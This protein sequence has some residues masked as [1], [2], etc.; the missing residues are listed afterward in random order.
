MDVLMDGPASALDVAAEAGIH[1]DT[2]RRV[3][4]HLQ[5]AGLVE[6]WGFAAS[7]SARPILQY[8]MARTKKAA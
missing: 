2:A 3:I 1:E 7:G 8:Q 4:R 5:A 6:T